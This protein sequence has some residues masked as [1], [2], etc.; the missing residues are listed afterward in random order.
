MIDEESNVLTRVFLLYPARL[1]TCYFL[2][3]ALLLRS[4]WELLTSS[5][6]KQK[7]TGKK[8]LITGGRSPFTLGLIRM[9]HNS[10]IFLW[11]HID[12]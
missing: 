8:V 2:A 11:L 10:G 6:I 9:F 12:S 5:N 7:P 3:I 4:V 1:V